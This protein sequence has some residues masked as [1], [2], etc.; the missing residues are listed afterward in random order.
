MPGV[1]LLAASELLQPGL[2]GR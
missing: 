2:R 1:S